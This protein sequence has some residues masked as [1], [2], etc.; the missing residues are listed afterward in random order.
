MKR[1]KRRRSRVKMKRSRW[2]SATWN[3]PWSTHPAWKT[4]TFLF[5]AWKWLAFAS[6][7]SSVLFRNGDLLRARLQTSISGC[8][9]IPANVSELSH[10]RGRDV[11]S[12]Q[13][14]VLFNDSRLSLVCVPTRAPSW[15]SKAASWGLNA[16]LQTQEQQ[17]IKQSKASASPTTTL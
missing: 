10:S 13:E 3:V 12:W 14:N 1:E 16:R 8:E 2:K 11:T 15:N 7:D 6:H 4:G 5:D 9:G 17:D